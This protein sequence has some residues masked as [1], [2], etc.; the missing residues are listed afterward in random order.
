LLFG[1][2]ACAPAA[3]G[4]GGAPRKRPVEKLPAEVRAPYRREEARVKL[5][6]S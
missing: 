6:Q 2:P 4:G 1:A 3:G 5:R